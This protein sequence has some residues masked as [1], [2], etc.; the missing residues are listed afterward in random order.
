MLR[1]PRI[2][3]DFQRRDNSNTSQTI[4]QNINRRNSAKLYEATVTP[5]PKTHKESTKQISDTFT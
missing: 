5:I 4:P 3:P 1:E 2:L